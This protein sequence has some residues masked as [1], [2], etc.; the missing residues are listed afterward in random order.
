MDP[1]HLTGC[2]VGLYTPALVRMC[3]QTTTS[4]A[5]DVPTANLSWGR[6][7]SV[8]DTILT[9][10]ALGVRLRLFGIQ[11]QPA[12]Y[13]GLAACYMHVWGALTSKIAPPPPRA[14]APAI[15][16]HVSKHGL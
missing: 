6:A 13:N 8:C 11:Q 3:T 14:A 7:E 5:Q 4:G 12:R 16:R 15:H 1:E 10:A 9:H 2:R